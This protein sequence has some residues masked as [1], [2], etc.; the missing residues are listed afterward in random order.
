MNTKTIGIRLRPTG[1]TQPMEVVLDSDTT[2]SS[3]STS[4]SVECAGQQQPTQTS[5]PDTN[6]TRDSLH[7]SR[8]WYV[9]TAGPACTRN[10]RLQELVKSFP[11]RLRYAI[12]SQSCQ[13]AQG[14]CSY[15]KGEV[16]HHWY[17]YLNHQI[18]KV[19]MQRVFWMANTWLEPLKTYKPEHTLPQ[20]QSYYLRYIRSKGEDSLSWGDL[21][22]DQ[23]QTQ[24]RDQTKTAKV[25]Q[26]I[27]AGMRLS[28]IIR[29][30]GLEAMQIPGSKL[31]RYRPHRKVTTKV[32]YIYGPP[33]VGKTYFIM[34]WLRSL[35]YYN[36]ELATY[37]KVMGLSKWYDGYDNEPIVLIDDPVI[38]SS[39]PTFMEQVQT[40]RNMIS[41]GPAYCEIKGSTWVF[42]S[43]VIVIVCNKSPAQL[44]HDCGSDNQ[45][46]MF[47]RFTDTRQPVFLAERNDMWRLDEALHELMQDEFPD[48]YIVYFNCSKSVNTAEGLV[49][50]CINM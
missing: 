24:T 28:Q 15:M 45:E 36:P 27:Q 23:T 6:W 38:M 37:C 34:Q 21:P 48:K 32:L 44:S 39:S 16:H 30:P 33:G 22:A 25:L 7:E 26:I 18:T 20:A 1:Q 2:S 4:L 35:H 29:T 46:A 11:E 31:M 49:Y 9:T 14:K 8:H 40:L 43:H 50:E 17:I 19:R 10:L 12:V 5:C 13:N 42:D 3:K 41:T 47:R